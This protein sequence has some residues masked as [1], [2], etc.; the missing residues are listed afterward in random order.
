MLGLQSPI[1]DNVESSRC[2]LNGWPN[3]YASQFSPTAL[4]LPPN[5][6]GRELRARRKRRTERLL[7]AEK[8]SAGASRAETLFWL[9]PGPESMSFLNAVL[10]QETDQPQIASIGSW[11]DASTSFQEAVIKWLG[12]TTTSV[13]RLAVGA[14][15]LHEVDSRE[16]AYKTLD[17]LLASVAIDPEM[18]ELVFRCNWPVESKVVAGLMVNRITS[19]SALRATRNLLQVTGESFN[20][21]SG[22]ELHAVRLEIDHSTDQAHS[23]PFESGQLIPIF[24]ELIEL[25]QQNAE[26]GER[27]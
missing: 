1:A 17:E 10:K 4:S 11:K 19:W 26:K 8:C 13:V 22:P 14:I 16:I 2:R 27:P 7:P 20:V 6:T 15:L 23:T 21:V 12:Q 5:K 18:K 24:K 3:S 25:A 9:F